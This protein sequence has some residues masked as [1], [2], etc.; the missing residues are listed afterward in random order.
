ML[1][2]GP[3]GRD[4]TELG[5]QQ[6]EQLAEDL[7][8]E[9]IGALIVSDLVRTQQTAAPLAARLG[10]EPLIHADGRE[11]FAGDLEDA[12]DQQSQELYART[13]FSWVEGDR[14]ARIPGG[15]SG[16]EVLARFDRQ[17]ERAFTATEQSGRTVAA[18]IAHG[19]V[20]RVWA[21]A[22]A[23]GADATFIA[24]HPL[25]NTNIIEVEGSPR[26]GWRLVSYAGLSAQQ[27]ADGIDDSRAE[28][29]A[30]DERQGTFGG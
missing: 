17:V 5:R 8:T 29:V 4:L 15:E 18:I 26:E 25:P 2:S 6:A 11:I 20:L 1:D 22:R 27:I 30:R 12:T 7:A 28:E 9:D 3:P 14:N 13:A 21:G 16:T 24:S 23:A 10:L 19:A